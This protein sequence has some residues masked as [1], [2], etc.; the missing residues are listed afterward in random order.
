LRFS[1]FFCMLFMAITSACVAEQTL[2]DAE[3]FQREIGGG[4]YWR[5]YQF[6][7]LYGLKESVSIIEAD[8]T[9]PSVY[10]RFP[11]LASTRGLLST[12]TPDQYPT[13][14]GAVNGTFFDTSAGGGGSTTFLR[15]NDTIIT[16][17][18]YKSWSDNAGITNTSSEFVRIQTRP[19]TTDGWNGITNRRD[20][21][22]N[23]PRL[24]KAGVVQTYDTVGSHCSA[25]HPRT[26]LGLNTTTRHLFLVTVDGRT[27]QSEGMTCDEMTRLMQELGC[28]EAF[29][30]DGGGSTTMW[31]NGEP[32]SGVVNYP[33]D[34]SKYDHLGQRSCS[35]AIAI[36]A[37]AAAPVA[38]DG[39][40][41]STDYDSLMLSGSTQ[42]VTLTYENIGTE[43]WTP[44]ST[45]LE[46]TRPRTRD[47]DFY[48]TDTWIT[49]QIPAQLSE[50]S[51]ASG[52]TGTFTFHFTAPE[53]SSG[54]IFTETF[55]LTQSGVGNFGPADDEARFEID[56][57]PEDSATS[58]T[59]IIESR[60][61]G[62]N[63]TRY[64]EQGGWADTSVN[65]TAPGCTGTIGDR[66][67]STYQS[68]AGFKEAFFTPNFSD[69]GLYEVFI[70][71]GSSSLSRSPITY[72]VTD[73]EGSTTYEIDQ[74]VNTNTWISLGSHTFAAGTG[75]FV[76]VSNANTDLSGNM[77][78][79]AV[80]FEM[81]T[82]PVE[83]SR[84]SA[85]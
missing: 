70:A 29:S 81:S 9:S 84:F 60:A 71:Y 15:V 67:G 42:T 2:A 48:T 19:G 78:A 13:A 55:G 20:I 14:V 24:I 7:D 77:Y 22:V 44:E 52:E 30:V 69:G 35:N 6:D 39:R 62:Q 58:G 63:F 82:T 72:T 64:S 16:P 23:G 38:W 11:Y 8:L 3:W 34:D 10:V 50:T 83:I 46:V 4:V 59:F 56:V 65:V 26:F 21:L 28:D 51:V 12:Y 41:L 49:S 5:H 53:V 54:K 27:D 74:T 68:V 76:S 37:P 45:V 36:L 73:A 61:G 43:T 75:G 47:S 1:L 79:G 25:R 33:S 40:L 31:V 80:K 66:Y 32:N 85:E 17:Q 57:E 18:T